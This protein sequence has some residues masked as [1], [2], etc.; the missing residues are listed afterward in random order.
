M[1]LLRLLTK[2]ASLVDFVRDGWI[3][4]KCGVD[5][6]AWWFGRAKIGSKA[7]IAK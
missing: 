1:E 6:A 5:K 3:I 4:A 7:H 2:S